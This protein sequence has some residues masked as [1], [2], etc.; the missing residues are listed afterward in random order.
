MNTSQKVVSFLSADHCS[1][2][3]DGW[4]VEL[5]AGCAESGRYVSC[6]GCVDVGCSRHS[7]MSTSENVYIVTCPY[8]TQMPKR[9]VKY[10]DSKAVDEFYALGLDTWLEIDNHM[11]DENR[12]GVGTDY[13]LMDVRVYIQIGKEGR[14]ENCDNKYI[15]FYRNDWIELRRSRGPE[16]F[17][18]VVVDEYGVIWTGKKYHNCKFRVFIKRESNE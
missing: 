8:I 12:I 14:T 7:T 6:S 3:A 15:L 17:Q 1:K 16:K 5:G 10:D 4:L 2:V 18:P 13:S 11:I 9:V